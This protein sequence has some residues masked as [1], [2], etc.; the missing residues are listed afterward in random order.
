MPA[1]TYEVP[2]T[3][4]LPV[5]TPFLQLEATD[6]DS[7]QYSNIIYSFASTSSVQNNLV[8]ILFL[9]VRECVC[10]RERWWG[11]VG[12]LQRASEYWRGNMAAIFLLFLLILCGGGILP[13]WVVRHP[14]S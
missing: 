7:D 10:V 14:F 13:Y 1:E 9:C 6:A 5:G 2:L 12:V 3:E 11:R 8:R 4:G